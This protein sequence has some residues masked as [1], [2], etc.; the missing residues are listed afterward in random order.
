MANEFNIQVIQDGT[1]N[2]VI[3]AT[4]VLT[5][6]DL[7]QQVLID[8]A[9]TQGIDNTGNLKASAFRIQRMIYVVEEGLAV[10]LWWDATTPVR[11]EDLVKAG[12]MEYREFGGLP[13]N[14]GVGKTGKI[15]I[16]TQGWTAGATLSFSVVMHLTKT[17][18]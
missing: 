5:A 16:G 9:L 18:G 3:K 13:S 17:Q 12:H 11:I 2:L 10:N 4:G 7:A 15:L 1:R 14:A 6:S 8:P